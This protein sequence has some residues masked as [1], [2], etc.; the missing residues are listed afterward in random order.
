MKLKIQLFLLLSCFVQLYGQKNLGSK[1]L[2]NLKELKYIAITNDLERIY[3]N[4]YL[5]DSL[6]N[7]I[8]QYNKQLPDIGAYN[9]YLVKLD[10][11]KLAVNSCLCFNGVSELNYELLILRNKNTNKATVFFA[12]YELLSD[13][14]Y[15][16]MS[17]TIKA[18][19]IILKESGATEGEN[20]QAEVISKSSHTIKIL[21]NGA[22]SI[23]T[24]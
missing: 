2:P 4:P 15:Y 20:G 17:Y 24:H 11:H 23:S 13:S 18:N 9:L 6:P 21:K 1:L 22:L 10:C 5:K 8:K 12:S 14:E 3:P 19:Q 7:L 16:Q